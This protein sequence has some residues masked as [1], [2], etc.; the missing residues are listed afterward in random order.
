MFHKIE[1]C[2]VYACL[3][4]DPVEG[5]TAESIASGIIAPTLA[6]ESSTSITVIWSPPKNPNGIILRYELLR[7]DLLPCSEE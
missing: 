5:T 7:Q 4:S 3:K 1:V 2:T 6:V